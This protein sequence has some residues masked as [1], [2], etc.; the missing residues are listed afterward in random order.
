ADKNQLVHWRNG[1]PETGGDEYSSREEWEKGQT[2][3]VKHRGAW[4]GNDTIWRMTA[5]L[6]RGMMKRERRYFSVIDGITAGEGQGPFC[7]T[8]KNAETIMAGENL[9]AC[10]F[11]AVRY[12]GFDPLRISYLKYFA[13][14]GYISPEE[15]NVTVDGKISDDFFTS[16]SKYLDFKTVKQWECIK[17]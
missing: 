7:P 3:K 16:P 14:T 5:D 1:Y 10:D 15:I 8:S 2:A 12:M 11:A 17:L 4:P 9:P 13:D 6:W